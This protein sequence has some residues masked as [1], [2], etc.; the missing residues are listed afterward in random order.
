MN[1]R[2]VLTVSVIHR[3][4]SAEQ[5]AHV[6][7][8]LMEIRCR[9]LDFSYTLFIYCSHINGHLFGTIFCPLHGG[10]I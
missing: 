4:S 6:R 9:L 1:A 8:F 10:K 2:R 7:D 3:F 5:L